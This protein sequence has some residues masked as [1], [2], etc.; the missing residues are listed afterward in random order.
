MSQGTVWFTTGVHPWTFNT[1]SCHRAK[2]E[3]QSD[4]LLFARETAAIE[5]VCISHLKIT[6]R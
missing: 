6:N 1:G 2:E 4:M 3:R 5:P